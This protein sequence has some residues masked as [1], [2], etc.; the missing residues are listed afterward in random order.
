MSNR[1]F[2]IE[3]DKNGNISSI[4][5][6]RAERN[7]LKGTGNVFQAFEDKPKDYDAWEISVYYQQKMWEVNDFCGAEVIEN[8]TERGVLRIKRK[9]VN[10]EI[11]QDICI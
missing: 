7:V 4:Y 11:V 10:S 3:I 8:G 2:D 9:F 1:F 6:K 5:D